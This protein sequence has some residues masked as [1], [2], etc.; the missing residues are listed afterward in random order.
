MED[1][2]NRRIVDLSVPIGSNYPCFYFRGQQFHQILLQDFDGPRGA[3]RSNF[4]IMEEHTGTHCDAPNHMIPAPDSKFEHAGEAHYVTVEKIPL[5]KCIGPAA[6]IDCRELLGTEKPG[7]SPVIKAEKIME[8]E[9]RNGKLK[10]SD[11]VLIFTSW[12]ELYYKPFPAGYKLEKE[13]NEDHTSEGWPAPDEN[14]ME[15]LIERN[16]QHV[17]CDFPSLGQIQ[18]DEGP[19]WVALGKE[20]VVVEK[21]INLSKLPA[22]G[23]FYMFL[24]LKIVNGTGAPG[25]AIAI[26]D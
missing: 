6:V 12:T 19:H 14:F 25:R 8:W 2:P 16:V 20:M 15:L 17:G 10:S 21:L 26:L 13:C 9:K 7:R 1:F 18:N 3:F 23:A 4:M 22:R 11:K 24:P 5:E